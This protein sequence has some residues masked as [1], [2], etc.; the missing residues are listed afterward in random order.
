MKALA[1]GRVANI[2]VLPEPS[3]AEVRD[4]AVASG[5]RSDPDNT[6]FAERLTR[7]FRTPKLL[8]AWRRDPSLAARW[9]L[10]QADK[11]AIEAAAW[12]YLLSDRQW[13]T[14][15][16]QML[17]HA[18][19][20]VDAEYLAVRLGRSVDE[21]RADLT[22]AEA[23]GLV[24]RT[25]STT[26]APH[27]AESFDTSPRAVR[28]AWLPISDGAGAVLVD[29]WYR[30]HQHRV[31]A[32]IRALPPD[33]AVDAIIT[34]WNMLS[35]ISTEAAATHTLRVVRSLDPDRQ[36]GLLVRGPEVWS[37][38]VDLLREAI[39]NVRKALER[40]PNILGLVDDLAL[41]AL[42]H[43]RLIADALSLVAT[44][45][46]A[47]LR[48]PYANRGVAGLTETLVNPGH[49][50]P[51]GYA[52][53]GLTW[54]RRVVERG[55]D[56]VTLTMAAAA[57]G[58][59]LRP[60]FHWEVA[61][62]LGMRIG[63][64]G[65][66]DDDA[67][68][69]GFV[70]AGAILQHLLASPDDAIWMSGVSA[71][72]VHDGGE[73]RVPAQAKVIH[74]A[75]GALVEQQRDDLSMVRRDA[76]ER[77]LP[78][79]VFDS[80]SAPHMDSFMSGLSDDPRV[81]A[82]RYTVAGASATPP[83]AL[84]RAHG[85]GPRAV[86]DV[87][88]DWQAVEQHVLELA[89]E[90]H[91]AGAGADVV[92]EMLVDLDGALALL[93]ERD[94]RTDLLLAW[95]RL[96]PD[97]FRQLLDESWSAWGP[98]AQW[99]LGAVAAQVLAAEVRR[100]VIEVTDH[101]D[102]MGFAQALS[103][104]VRDPSTA[105]R[106]EVRL[107][108]GVVKTASWGA[109]DV[110][111]ILRFARLLPPSL[112]GELT[113]WWVRLVDNG[114][115]PQPDLD[116][117]FRLM[118]VPGIEAGAFDELN[119]KVNYLGE[120]WKLDAGCEGAFLDALERVYPLDG[121]AKLSLYDPAKRALVA[122]V[123]NARPERFWSIRWEAWV[124]GASQHAGLDAQQCLRVLSFAPEP[125]EDH[126]HEMIYDALVRAVEGTALREHLGSLLPDAPRRRALLLGAGMRTGLAQ[127]T[128][129][130]LDA[131]EDEQLAQRLARRIA[132]DLGTA[133]FR[134]GR[135][136]MVA[137]FPEHPAPRSVDPVAEE[138][139]A[140]GATAGGRTGDLLVY[141]ADLRTGSETLF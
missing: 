59:W 10:E 88:H 46:R 94:P 69:R 133:G 106:S 23:A 118:L 79:V 119:G 109:W 130:T 5:D 61:D 131:I 126:A 25:A 100:I 47:G 99:V 91:S 7:W 13:T 77:L 87:L 121:Q 60:I 78:A 12:T 90:L 72:R 114:P 44:A 135:T 32:T 33:E 116:E 137:A 68:A 39:G 125:V 73:G 134:A 75:I 89:H 41:G 65:W 136:V 11:G 21:W 55:P 63:Q 16:A 70:A 111:A 102:G 3:L 18:A 76:I 56:A 110:E 4:W 115:E 45:G 95:A 26:Q 43:P 122:R 129:D 14:W 22:A 27:D 9:V 34:L 104:F 105:S 112:R 128:Y 140:F 117:V 19:G 101:A 120:R 42:Q 48:S 58:V 15:P 80:A 93:E 84:R 67:T 83:S 57:L 40:T 8:D 108:I 50:M 139:R 38:H 31:D 123:I 96:N 127:T 124:G 85:A 35:A 107:L 2:V 36:V 132:G 1:R 74:A 138:Y 141:M 20:R 51:F 28:P 66:P 52:A 81:R 64:A 17:G 37:A 98:S 92:R 86:L 113:G 6:H 82:W 53:D 29:L 49:G 24:R 71:L 30:D 54:L 62:E 103:R 97:L